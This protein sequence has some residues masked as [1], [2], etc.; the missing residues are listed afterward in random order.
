MAYIGLALGVYSHDGASGSAS[1]L[2]SGLYFSALL[3]MTNFITIKP[4]Q[5]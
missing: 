3:D 5:E 4:E 1:V 2:S